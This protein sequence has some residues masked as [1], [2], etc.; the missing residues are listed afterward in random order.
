[1]SNFNT[2]KLLSELTL[3]EKLAQ[4]T[5]L[6]ANFLCDSRAAITGP[7][8]NLK[9]SEA[10]IA[11]VGTTLNFN[12]SAEMKNVQD[13]HMD[14]DPHKIPLLFMQDVIHG[15]RTIYPIPLAMGA[16][17]DTALMEKCCA[18]AAR[19][20][21][22][23]GVQV[24]FAPM[25]DLARDARWGRVMES[26]GEDPYLNCLMARAQVRGYQNG[27]EDPKENLS[28]CVKHYAAYGAAE[29]GRDYNTVDMSEHNLR[30]Y[31]LP[32]YRAA[33]DEG[34][35]MVMPG[36]HVTITVTLIYPVALNEGLRFAIREGGRTVGA[37]QVLKVLE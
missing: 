17:F 18:M 11:A 22:A 16:T 34:V 6:N 28:A 4:M 8:S 12:G 5:Q 21:T 35:D 7:A 27:N 33:I 3:R 2:K 20:A 9:I 25:V 13:S 24:T 30:E 23:A 26:T 32:S 1:M 15:Y 37:G 14:A 29:A 10:D 31:Y 36:D 19:E